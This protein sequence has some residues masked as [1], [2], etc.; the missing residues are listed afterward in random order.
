MCCGDTVFFVC[1][2]KWMEFNTDFSMY[3]VSA[4][5]QLSNRVPGYVRQPQRRNPMGRHSLCH[6]APGHPPM[7]DLLDTHC[8]ANIQKFEKGDITA[9]V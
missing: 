6:V 4:R 8:R 2:H 7:I 3:S 9:T 5:L 1:H